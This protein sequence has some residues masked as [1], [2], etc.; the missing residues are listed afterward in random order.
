MADTEAPLH[1]QLR[2]SILGRIQRGELQVGDKMPGELDLMAL[3]SVSR[4]TVRRAMSDLASDGYIVRQRGRG[5]FVAE[6]KILHF[7][8]RI[9]GL[10]PDLERQGYAVKQRVIEHRRCPAGENAARYLSVGAN[11]EVLKDRRLVLGDDMPLALITGYFNVASSLIIEDGDV[12]SG[13]ML[14]TLREKYGLPV[15]RINRRIE[16]T[17]C[18]ADDVDLLLAPP[19][20]PMLVG[21][22][23][24]LDDFERPLAYSRAVYRGDRYKY[25]QSFTYD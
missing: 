18:D 14:T 12:Q 23:T 20:L 4:I 2:R 10:T 7:E 13:Y 16:A 1:L 5:S 21:E 3:H 11:E 8:G 24:A 17:L 25:F 22:V 9:D 19:G 15:K 6:P